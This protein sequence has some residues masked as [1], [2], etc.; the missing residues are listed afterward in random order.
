MAIM[1]GIDINAM[2]RRGKRSR[3]SAWHSFKLPA[4]SLTPREKDVCR[5]LLEGLALKE[6]AGRLAMSP[7]TASCHNRSLYQKLGIHSR[8]ELFK[9]FFNAPVVE[10]RDTPMEPGNVEIVTRLELIE[11]RLGQLAQQLTYNVAQVA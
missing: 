9:H 5:L 1:I 6:V 4:D 2:A 11:A 7:S 10:D 3:A 8:A